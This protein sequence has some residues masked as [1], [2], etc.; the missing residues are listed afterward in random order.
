MSAFPDAP[1]GRAVS[2]PGRSRAA[3]VGR[4]LGNPQLPQLICAAGMV[5]LRHGQCEHWDL[6]QAVTGTYLS[7]VRNL[8][9]A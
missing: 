9:G 2:R 3:E 6:S 4:A 7:P 5:F 1:R 8:E